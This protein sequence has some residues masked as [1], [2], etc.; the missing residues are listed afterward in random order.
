MKKTYFVKGPVNHEHLKDSALYQ[1][2]YS[3]YI[4]WYIPYCGVFYKSRKNHETPKLQHWSSGKHMIW[5]RSLLQCQLHYSVFAKHNNSNL[6]DF[7]HNHDNFE[8]LCLAKITESI[9]VHLPIPN[10]ADWKNTAIWN[11]PTMLFGIQ[12]LVQR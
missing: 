10:Y 11:L 8:L 5:N 9:E 4:A 1:V 7:F 6:L 2:L 3:K 12:Y